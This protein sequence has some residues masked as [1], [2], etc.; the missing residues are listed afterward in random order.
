MAVRQTATSN[1]G[2]GRAWFVAACLV[3]LFIAALFL[4]AYWN[5]DA[6]APT[7]GNYVLSGG[8]DPYY[9][10]RAIDAIQ[11]GTSE[12]P[13]RTLIDDPMLNYPIGSVNPNPPL[14]QWSVAVAGSLLGGFFD[15]GV[16]EATWWATLWAPAIYGALT[17]FPIFFIGKTLFD[18]RAGLVAALLW[19]LST[20]AID[21]T[22]LGLADHDA[23]VMFFASLA[24]LFYI[25]TIQHFRGDGNW[26]TNW[27][28]GG[29]VSAGLGRMFRERSGGFAYA[30]LTGVSISAVALTWKG[31]PYVLGIV[32]IYAILQMVVDHWRNRDSTGLFAA[33][34]LAMLVG[35]LLAYPYYAQAGVANFLRPVWFIIG[36]F[37][38][39]GIV[40]VPTRDLPT[41]LVMPIAA[42]VGILGA[43]VA[44]FV[45]PDVARSLLY[46]TVYFKQ[47][48][49]Y[50]TI[51][52]A[53]AADFSTI[54]FGIG[55][56]PFFLALVGWVVLAFT[57]RR[58]P[59]RAILFALVWGAVALYMAHSAV[60]FLFNAIPVFCVFA[61]YM[62]V[63]ILDWLDF[64]SIR[65][66]LAANRGNSWQGFRKGLRPMH[67]IGAILIVLLFVAPN[68]MLAADAALPPE[69]ETRI[70]S[71]SDSD[72]VKGF[73]SKRMGAYGQGFIPGYWLDGLQWLDEYDS[74]TA[75]PAARP[76]FLSWWDYG[77]WAIAVGRH[78][79][80]ADNFQNGY[81]FAANFILSQNETQA[82]QLLA[83]RLSVL[84]SS[85]AEAALAEVGS[86]D[87]AGDLKKLQNWEYVDGLSLDQS[88]QLVSKL[89]ANT[90]K[91]IRY[92]A[93]DV[94]MFPYDDPSTQSIEQSSIYYAPVTLKGDDPDKYVA[95]KI[96]IGTVDRQ[97]GSS[98]VNQ[99]R[100]E[101]L[102]SDPIRLTQ[103]MGERL[104]YQQA[105]FNSMYWRAYVGTPVQA[106][107][108]TSPV[109]GD[110]VLQALNQ[111]MPAY[112]M[113]HFRLVYSSDALRIIE[114]YPG[115]IVEGTVT[116]EGTP[117]AGV[118][119]I[120]YDDA[121]K[122]LLSGANESALAGLD[123]AD[124]SVPHSAATTDADGK[125][126]LTAP[127]A[128]EGGNVT[129]VA[130]RDGVEVG[131]ARVDIT[132]AD[133]NAGRTFTGVDLT[134]QRGS[135]EGVVFVDS[136]GDGRFDATNETPLADANVTVGDRSATTGADGS[137][138]IDGI[139]S[140]TQNVTLASDQYQVVAA[141]QRVSVP[142]GGTATHNVGVQ[143]KPATVAGVVYADQDGDG[144]PGENEPVSFQSVT[145]RPDTTVE[146]NTA[147]AAATTT[148]A[149]GE[150]MVE[151]RP[152]SYVVTSTW[153]NAVDQAE[154]TLEEQLVVTSGATETLDLRLTRAAAE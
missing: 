137:Y 150:Y 91:S 83:A 90:G 118:T 99:S 88:V 28:A 32:F 67:M 129:L 154:Y 114:Y 151:L 108:Q 3:V 14:F 116:E 24:F 23:T 132:R 79:A 134:L 127:F 63:W 17:L 111:P 121:G 69:T 45:V 64:G 29:T 138:R 131:R 19:T 50:E 87:P 70:A 143:E 41:I 11:A 103:P 96:D 2:N 53:H 123:L 92:F 25:K 147:V 130:R 47:T 57:I 74:D 31:F 109:L 65:K 124:Y 66:S 9:H 115:A 71:E 75:D 100:Y 80:V 62:T 1:G 144:A 141:S 97:T 72:F 35:T 44:F 78:P 82:V 125:Y 146:G 142:S 85:N 106:E 38:V 77:H 10:K 8:S 128:M 42:L 59:T 86:A 113:E 7:E 101:Q 93:V 94:R 84:D 51:A 107:G 126:R 46:A 102:A 33:T 30:L 26:V 52:E 145:F 76:G 89:E 36:A 110:T 61:G 73:M 148:T 133:S 16:S 39:T 120:A 5:L 149:T 40:L 119:V 4:R 81:E 20:S 95:V 98:F 58:H 13:F 55:P 60:R 12:G 15:G 152:G 48:R 135:V 43:V 18:R 21:A 140:G 122:L 136:N 117:L 104:E 68:V 139:S 49:L 54:L 34:L 112:G 153:T 37:F 56:L 22:G 6:A 105:F 27:R